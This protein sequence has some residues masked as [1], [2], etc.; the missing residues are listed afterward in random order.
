[1]KKRHVTPED[2][3]QRLSFAWGGG[4]CELGGGG[5]TWWRNQLV[6]R[7]SEELDLQGARRQVKGKA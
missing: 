3:D 6:Q 5:K 4:A 1:L 7:E 2:R